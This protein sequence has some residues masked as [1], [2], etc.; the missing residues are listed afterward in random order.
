MIP[1]KEYQKANRN[2]QIAQC[3]KTTTQVMLINEID[4]KDVNWS[5]K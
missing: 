1:E 3:K 2:Q 5:V 4:G